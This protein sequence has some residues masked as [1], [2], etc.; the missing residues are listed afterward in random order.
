MDLY[1]ATRSDAPH[2]L[3]IGRSSNARSRCSQ[4]ENGHCFRIHVL[5]IFRGMGA[6]EAPVHRALKECRLDNSEWFATDMLTAVET[7]Q[8]AQPQR[9]RARRIDLEAQALKR[10][11]RGSTLKSTRYPHLNTSPRMTMQR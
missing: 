1:L 4:L 11:L 6:C 9:Q 7:I 5:A 2:L 8:E 10:K 3:K